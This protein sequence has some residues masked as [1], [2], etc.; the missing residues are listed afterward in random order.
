MVITVRRLGHPLQVPLDAVAAD[1]IRVLA[2]LIEPVG[3]GLR[4]LVL[5]ALLKVGAHNA[6][7]RRQHAHEFGVEQ[8]ACG[9]VVGTHAAG[10]GIVH[11]RFQDAFQVGVAH[12]T[13]GGG[14]VV[15]LHGH[16]QLIADVDL[17]IG[18]DQTGVQTIIDELLNG[19]GDHS[20]APPSGR[21]LS[22]WQRPSPRMASI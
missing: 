21:M 20:T 19:S 15:Q 16:E 8:V 17:V 11:Q 22:T 7:T 14:K 9:A 4:A 3:G 18:Q 13:L 1:I 6:G 5:V 2:E 12:L 10:H